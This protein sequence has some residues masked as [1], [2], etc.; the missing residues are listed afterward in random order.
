MART[1]L[2]ALLLMVLMTF[3]SPIAQAHLLNVFAFA[4]GNHITGSVYFVGGTPAS[5]AVVSVM[6][7]D[8]RLLATL[9]PNAEGEFSYQATTAEDHVI[10]ADTGDGHV[11]QWRVSS[12]ELTGSSKARPKDP[13]MTPET[14]SSTNDSELSAMIEAAVARQVQPL[15]KQMIDYDEQIRLQDIIG[16]IGYILGV[17]GLIAWWQQ[18]RKAGQ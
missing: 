4:D 8:N 18:K 14:V 5:G 1:S 15:R 6:S 7:A 11:A 2:L 17:F 9:E 16:G 13:A 10:V 12:A 3:I